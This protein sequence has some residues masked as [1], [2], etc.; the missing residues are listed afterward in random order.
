[1]SVTITDEQYAE[2]MFYARSLRD[3]NEHD[4]A[5]GKRRYFT[6]SRH[7]YDRLSALVAGWG[8]S[9]DETEAEIRAKI[10]IWSQPTCP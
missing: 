7:H 6:Q 8:S 5:D 1:M 10:L 2:L 3:G 9:V 4:I